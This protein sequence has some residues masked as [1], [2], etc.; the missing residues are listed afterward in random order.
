MNEQELN[1]KLNDWAGTTDVDYA[2]PTFGIAYCFKWLVP[3]LN[4]KLDR[5]IE[6]YQSTS[7]WICN[8]GLGDVEVENKNPSLALRLAIEE[9]IDSEVK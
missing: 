3:T 5:H 2:H 1:K 6:L 4:D 8:I 9:I 7:G